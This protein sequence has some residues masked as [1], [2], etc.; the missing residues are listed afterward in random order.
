MC[1]LVE[2]L[3]VLVPHPHRVDNRV[4]DVLVEL[5]WSE[6]VVA[7]AKTDIR[8]VNEHAHQVLLGQVV[9]VLT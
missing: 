1:H 5:V 9:L 6:D 3:L 7:A 8:E 2:T 4:L